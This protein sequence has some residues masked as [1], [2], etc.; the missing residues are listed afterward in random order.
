[1][2]SS[3]YLTIYNYASYLNFAP[4]SGYLVTQNFAILPN[5]N[6]ALQANETWTHWTAETTPV[7][8][9][10][11]PENYAMLLAGLCLVGTVVKRREAKET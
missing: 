7:T 10:P 8:S 9:V 1:M 6:M 5:T 11:E 3:P 2:S 4:N